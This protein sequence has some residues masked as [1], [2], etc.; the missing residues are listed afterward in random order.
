MQ[1]FGFNTKQEAML[2]ALTE[3]VVKSSA[4]EGNVLDPNSV[5]SSIARRLRLNVA[6]VSPRE[7][8]DVE[9]VVQMMLDATQKYDQPLTEDRLFRWHA[10][11]FSGVRTTADKFRVGAWRDD[12]DGPM[13]V[14]SGPIGREKIH[15]VAPAAESI[16]K[17]MSQ[18]LDWFNSESEPDPLIKAGI[19]HLWFITVH[20]FE[21]GN[22]RIGRAIAEMCLAR[23]DKSAQRFYSMS[24]QILEERNEYYRV[25]E[26]TQKGSTEITKWLVWFLGC[27]D[28]SLEKAEALTEGAIRTESFWR[29]LGD[30]KIS[31]NNRQKKML[32]M[33]LNKFEGKLTTTKWAKITKCSQDTALSDIRS[34]IDAGVLEQEEAG[35][36]STS[37]KLREGIKP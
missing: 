32:N 18:Y 5:R 13:Q 36:R 23:S 4:I 34:L 12:S 17:E 11:L 16:P 21:D 8:R 26:E 20:P 25:L 19:A 24:A 10:H 35:G 27:L 33:L 2:S 22:G 3:E 15:Y 6:G 14:V 31:I 9:G 1:A 30:R 29:V 28:R 37:Y 7:D